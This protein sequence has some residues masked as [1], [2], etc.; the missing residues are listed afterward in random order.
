MDSIKIVL[1]KIEETKTDHRC[2]TIIDKQ[3]LEKI[4]SDLLILKIIKKYLKF[5]T[6]DTYLM[7]RED[8]YRIVSFEIVENYDDINNDFRN[9]KFWNEIQDGLR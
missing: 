9:I 2:F 4:L 3:D 5:E 8:T 1:E 7:K 6:V